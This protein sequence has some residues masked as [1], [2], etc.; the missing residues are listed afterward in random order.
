MYSSKDQ[1]VAKDEENRSASSDFTLSDKNLFNLR[2]STGSV[3][4]NIITYYIQF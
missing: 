4:V 2:P 3:S 1:Y